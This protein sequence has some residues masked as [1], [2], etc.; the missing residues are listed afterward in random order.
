MSV[1]GN[2]ACEVLV[3]RVLGSSLAALE[4]R[5]LSKACSML[6]DPLVSAVYLGSCHAEAQ[7]E[8]SADGARHAS[9]PRPYRFT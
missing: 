4:R 5:K 8:A 1:Q 9:Q 2:E 7:Q 3:K 6:F